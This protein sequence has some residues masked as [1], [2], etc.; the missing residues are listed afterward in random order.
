MQGLAHVKTRNLKTYCTI[1]IVSHA[2]LAQDQELSVILLSLVDIV[3]PGKY[4]IGTSRFRI[5]KNTIVLY[6]GTI[7]E[8]VGA[9]RQDSISPKAL[10][11]NASSFSGFQLLDANRRTNF[12][13]KSKGVDGSNVFIN[14]PTPDP[15]GSTHGCTGSSC[16][17]LT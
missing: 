2:L 9:A 12:Y 15:L 3:L 8:V 16:I 11:E 14:V 17:R 5:Q 1:T 10:L 4:N 13:P 7:A 6:R